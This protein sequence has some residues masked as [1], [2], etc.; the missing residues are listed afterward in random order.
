MCHSE[1]VQ[2]D[3]E[4]Y[5]FRTKILD[6]IGFKFCGKVLDIFTSNVSFSSLRISFPNTFVSLFLSISLSF[7][8]SVHHTFLFLFNFDVY[9]P[10]M[11]TI[12]GWNVK[13]FRTER[14][15]CFFAI[16]VVASARSV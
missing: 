14:V 16:R 11:S 2:F 7:L 13:Y 1:Q 4:S 3:N 10:K 8:F 6:L 5:S 15:V 9:K 12:L